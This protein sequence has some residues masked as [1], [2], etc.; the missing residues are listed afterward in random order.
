MHINKLNQKC[1]MDHLY[2]RKFRIIL[3]L[4]VPQIR[5][6]VPQTSLKV[7]EETSQVLDK[8]YA[9]N[10]TV[11]RELQIRREVVQRVTHVLDTSNIYY[12]FH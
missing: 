12:K 8:L 3:R 9:T 6:K 11:L 4:Q 1:I 7:P 2:A 5:L 10:L